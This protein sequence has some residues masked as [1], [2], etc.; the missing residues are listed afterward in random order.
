MRSTPLTVNAASELDFAQRRVLY[1]E[2]QALLV[3]EVPVLFLYW[4]EAFPAATD[5]CRRLLAQRLDA[6]CSGTPPTGISD[7]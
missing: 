3:Q 4:E 2:I 7:A 1:G 5:Q 6:R